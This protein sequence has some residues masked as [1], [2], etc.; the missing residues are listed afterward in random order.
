MSQAVPAAQRQAPNEAFS[1]VGVIGGGAWGTALASLVASNGVD[2]LIWVREPEVAQSVAECRENKLFLPGVALPGAL[3]ATTDL[4]EAA[5]RDALIFVA[6]V[7]F[8]R[9]TLAGLRRHAAPETPVA[10]CSKGI[11]AAS[12]LLMTEVL[13]EVWP[14]ARAAV[15]S[16]P[17]FAADVARGLPTAVALASGDP[18]L[19]ARWAATI[20]APHFRLYLSDD[21]VGAELG[22]AVKNVLAIAAGA[23]EGR[24]LGESA[25]A[26]VIAR[27]FAE[28]Q[29]LG[30]ALGAQRETLVGLSGLGDLILTAT[31]PES[32]NMS[33][34]RE[35]GRG[36]PLADILGER[37]S[38]SE[39]VATAAAVVAMAARVHVE[40]PV[41]EAVADLIAGRLTMDEITARLL[42]RPVRTEG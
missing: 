39:G 34:G 23:V 13:A 41:C 4:A 28:F 37:T 27:G 30:L 18:R 40:M 25:R 20:G 33:L 8:A 29:R 7:Q 42:A 2:T 11:E 31:S 10:L 14:E 17:S 32:R 38:V 15:L 22:G 35:L 36:R 6:P 16:G 26:A 3:R 9:P 12:G 21:L 5:V 24:G 1:S 19:G